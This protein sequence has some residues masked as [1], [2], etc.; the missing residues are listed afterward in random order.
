MC[1][2]LAQVPLNPREPAQLQL[3]RKQSRLPAPIAGYEHR[4][5]RRPLTGSSLPTG[6]NAKSW[7]TPHRRRLPAQPNAEQ[8]FAFI[9]GTIFVT[10]TRL[11]D[12]KEPIRG[13]SIIIRKARNE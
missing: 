11:E 8:S 1:R 13:S 12:R 6:G 7:G 4:K 10:S 2:Q 9:G 3:Y 5:A